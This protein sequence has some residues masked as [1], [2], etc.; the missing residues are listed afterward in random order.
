MEEEGT[1][2]RCSECNPGELVRSSCIDLGSEAKPIGRAV[3][4]LS[5]GRGHREGGD[6]LRALVLHAVRGGAGRGDDTRGKSVMTPL[7]SSSSMFL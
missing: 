5:Q 6:L 2:K 4:G 3:M 1:G 7:A